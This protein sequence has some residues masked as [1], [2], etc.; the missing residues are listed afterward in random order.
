MSNFPIELPP[1][2]EAKAEKLGIN[3]EEIE[4]SF[5]Q[6]SGAGGQKI[7]KT[8]NCVRL[9]LRKLEI[10]IKC[11][12]HRERSKNRLSAYKLLIDK[13]ETMLLGEESAEAQKIFKL[14]KQKM[15]RSKKAKAKML[16]EKH[17]HSEI[18]QRRHKI[19]LSN[20]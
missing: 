2:Y 20:E 15:R 18:K 12:K 13:V 19:D 16:E 9:N 10:E 17:H 14:R 8:S 3:P 1:E 7:N 4:E 11:Q 6:G 5:I